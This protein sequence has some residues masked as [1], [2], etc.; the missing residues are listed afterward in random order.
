[1]RKWIYTEN[2]R[3]I[4]NTDHIRRIR[5]SDPAFNQK[6]YCV[7]ADMPDGTDILFS[8]TNEACVDYID[9]FYNSETEH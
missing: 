8:G 6:E 9:E 2:M 3:L 7:V 1:M 4:L 5:I